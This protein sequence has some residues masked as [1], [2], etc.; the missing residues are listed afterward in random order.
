MKLYLYDQKHER[1]DAEMDVEN[2]EEVQR[3]ID[4]LWQHDVLNRYQSL[5]LAKSYRTVYIEEG[6]AE[7]K[8]D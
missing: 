2:I 5:T 6:F 1:V 7:L 8:F 3:I 4:F